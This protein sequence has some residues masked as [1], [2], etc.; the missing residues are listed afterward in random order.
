MKVGDI[1]KGVYQVE[2]VGKRY[3]GSSGLSISRRRTNHLSSLRRG[4]HEN[5]NLQQLFNEHGE[6]ALNFSILEATDDPKKCID[7]EQKY[8]DEICPELNIYPN[9]KSSA[10][11]KRSE[12]TKKKIGAASKGRRHTE[13]TKAKISAAGM[14]RIKS[15]ETR[16][17]LSESLKGHS[18]SEEVREKLKIYHAGL[19]SPMAGRKHTEEAKAKMSAAKK[20]KPNPNLS[21]NFSEETKQKMRDARLK[22]YENKCLQK[23]V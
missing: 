1:L 15:E 3:I 5:R 14:G 7:L 8:I 11:V 6:C 16:R 22:Y 4:I 2:I 12:E 18:V 21:R 17:K 23:N 20:G 19:P 10:G 13:E 9:A